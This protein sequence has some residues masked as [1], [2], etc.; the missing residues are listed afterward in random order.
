MDTVISFGSENL[1]VSSQGGG[2]AEQNQQQRGRQDPDPM[3]SVHTLSESFRI[4]APFSETQKNVD[5]GNRCYCILIAG[6]CQYFVTICRGERKQEP[7]P[8]GCRTPV[9][10][11]L[12]GSLPLQDSLPLRGSLPPRGPPLSCPDR[13]G[14]RCRPSSGPSRPR[15]WRWCRS[16]ARR[17]GPRWTAPSGRSAPPAGSWFPRRAA[18][19]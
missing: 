8:G 2:T 6:I 13:P 5:I 1:F 16:P 17:P 18:P 10:V 9:P 7:E 12:R 19:G 11:G 14:G 4:P 3:L 15:S